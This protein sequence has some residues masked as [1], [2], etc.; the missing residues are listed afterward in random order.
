MVDI[1]NLHRE[2]IEGIAYIDYR[3]YNGRLGNTWR[4]F[5]TRPSV[6]ERFLTSRH[7]RRCRLHASVRTNHTVRSDNRHSRHI[8]RNA[9][10][11]RGS[12][13]DTA[14]S[15]HHKDGV[16]SLLQTS[17]FITSLII[18][19][20]EGIL[21]FRTYRRSHRNRTVIAA[22]AESVLRRGGHRRIG[23]GK[24]CHIHGIRSFTTIGIGHC[25]HIIIDARSRLSRH[26]GHITDLQ[27]V[28]RHPRIGIVGCSVLRHRRHRHATTRT[29]DSVILGDDSCRHTWEQY[30]NGQCAAIVTT[31]CRRHRNGR[32]LRQHFTSSRCLRNSQV[33]L[34]CAVILQGSAYKRNI[35]RNHKS[36]C[37]ARKSAVGE[38]DIELRTHRIL[39]TEHL[40]D[41]I[42]YISALIRH[43]IG[44]R[45]DHRTGTRNNL[46]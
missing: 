23:Y 30:I 40:C 20:V 44:S 39:N 41:L 42:T 26:C 43:R 36:T 18:S 31:V 7:L 13:G 45:D 14:V 6:V 27:S 9:D 11:S 16:A 12:L 32:I 22:R 37:S 21:I 25:H 15:R 24:Y 28:N 35:V 1:F 33:G 29:E 34:T 38:G 8:L 46:R 5:G 10:H 19:A 3:C 4:R 2:D 17:K